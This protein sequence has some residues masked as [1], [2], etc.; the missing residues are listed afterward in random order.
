MNKKRIGIVVGVI[1]G[2][3]LVLVGA[4]LGARKR[5]ITT[6][7]ADTKLALH[8]LPHTV[9]L[10]LVKSE[11]PKHINKYPGVIRASDE[12]SLSFR[13]GGPLVKVNFI[14][15][16]S[17]AKG[18]LLMQLDQRDFEDRISLL[19]AQLKGAEAMLL[20]AGQDYDRASQLFGEKVIPQADYDHAGGAKD[21]ATAAVDTLKVQLEVARHSLKD[22]SLY[23]PYDGTVA[24]Q[25]AENYE[26]V[27]PGRVVLRY[28][29]IKQLE[30]LVNLPENEIIKH[31]TKGEKTVQVSFPA[32]SGKAC[33]ANLKEW[34]SVADPVTR[35]YAVIF[36]FK[37]PEDIIVLPGMS[38]EVSWPS[39]SAKE[40]LTVPFSSIATD[41]AGDSILWIYDSK[42]S[43]ATRRV[44]Q[45]GG[46]SGAKRVVILSGVSEGEQVVVGGSRLI[47]EELLI[48]SVSIDA[49]K[50][51]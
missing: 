9:S 49:S 20:N 32:I 38:A 3:I 4:L 15:G 42:N 30:V 23:A 33:V 18:E 50:S 14:L 16:N 17:V 45:L 48:Q 37:A 24:T 10:E 21:A 2:I 12:S 19:E 34:S 28:H 22:A 40:E 31:S 36:S 43:N 26:M 44:V 35:T 6:K 46:L 39:T 25:L 1:A 51:K 8:N 11:I 27:G 7:N 29:N 5:G 47:N 41:V 13:V